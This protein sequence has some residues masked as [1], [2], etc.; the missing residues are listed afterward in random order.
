MTT[1]N[2]VATAPPR[3]SD[4]MD[5]DRAF[6]PVLVMATT[7]W[8]T[9]ARRMVDTTPEMPKPSMISMMVITTINS[10]AVYALQFICFPN[11]SGRHWC[12]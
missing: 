8:F 10:I 7:A 6:S 12:L 11:W 4:A 1:P 5:S 9:A 2:T 3:L